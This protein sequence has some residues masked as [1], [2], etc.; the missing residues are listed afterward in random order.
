MFVP[1]RKMFSQECRYNFLFWSWT[2]SWVSHGWNVKGSEFWKA[3]WVRHLP[4]S[5]IGQYT[6]MG[7]FGQLKA[8]PDDAWPTLKYFWVLPQG[9]LI[10]AYKQS[11]LP[12]RITVLQ[13][14]LW[15][16]M[17]SVGFCPPLGLCHGFL[18]VTE[19]LNPHILP[20]LCF[21]FHEALP[22]CI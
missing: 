11:P 4:L 10:C 19:E 17:V 1:G 3:Q 18:A 12:L 14:V 16:T 5:D 21:V 2:L 13:Q 20:A 7:D 8:S 6:L 15:G 22:E 9:Y